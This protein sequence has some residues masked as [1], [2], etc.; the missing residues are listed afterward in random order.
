MIPL[1]QIVLDNIYG[2][3]FRACLASIF[4]FPIEEMPNFW[5]QTQNPEEFWELNDSWLVKNKGYRCMPVQFEPKDTHLI[6][7]IICIACGT[8]PRG[9]CD[10]AVVWQDGI[11][12]DPHPGSIGL[13]EEKPR[14]FTLFLPI[15]PVKFSE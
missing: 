9:D 11:I 3:C 6:D 13:V 14:D 7:G 10:H 1:N 4:E 8:S 15:N 12:H 2:D 5:E